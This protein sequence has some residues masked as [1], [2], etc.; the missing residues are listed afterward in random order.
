MINVL[1]TKK[2]QK[3]HLYPSP[4]ELEREQHTGPEE[5]TFSLP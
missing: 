1:M 2:Q 5:Q 3:P 4:A